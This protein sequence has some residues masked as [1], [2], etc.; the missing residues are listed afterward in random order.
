MQYGADVASDGTGALERTKKC[1]MLIIT[2]QG[3]GAGEAG[4]SL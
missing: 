2:Q 3:E 1:P 4:R